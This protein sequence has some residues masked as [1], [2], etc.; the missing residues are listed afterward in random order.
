MSLTTEQIQQI[1]ADA[2][3]EAIAI[4]IRAHGDGDYR[5]HE[6]IDIK[7]NIWRDCKPTW[8]RSVSP[9]HMLDDLKQIIEL[10]AQVERLQQLERD[11]LAKVKAARKV[12]EAALN[13]WI[14]NA[15]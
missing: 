5:A 4:T 12:A 9:T 1:L 10:Q 7:R 6:Y 8:Q 15:I 14:E 3:K 13:E 2:P 11:P